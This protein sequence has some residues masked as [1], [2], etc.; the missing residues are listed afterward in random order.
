M[1]FQETH[2]DAI[3]AAAIQSQK[4]NVLLNFITFRRHMRHT[5]TTA[6]RYDEHD[7]LEKKN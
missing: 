6:H 5:M 4:T 2:F 3:R 1:P 7:S